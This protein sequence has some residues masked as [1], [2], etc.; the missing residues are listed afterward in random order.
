M[1]QRERTPIGIIGGSGI[2]EIEGI[3]VIERVE[4]DTPFGKPSAPIVIG[5]LNG[6]RVAFLPRHGE[7]H[8]FNPSTV[9]YRANIWALKQLGVFWVVAVNAVG[10]LREAIAPGDFVIPD[11][12]IDKTYRRPNTLYDEL[13]VHVTLSDPFHPMLRQVLLDATR[14]ESINVHDG[15]TY[16]C[17]EGPAFSTR[18]E[19]H[20]HREWN[21]DLIGMTAQPEA[22]LAREAELC[23]ASVCLPT[24]YDT[25]RESEELDINDIFATLQQNTANVKRVLAAAIPRIPLDREDECDAAHAMRYA[26]MTKPAGISAETRARYGLVLEKYL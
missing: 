5:S 4:L 8:Q 22:R 14:A 21:A 19:S 23:Y 7:H 25:W 15:G 12:I 18:A 16:V 26:I 10:S 13:A 2:Y 6:R 3:E 9:P 24:D 20:L 11:Q 17:M 1:T